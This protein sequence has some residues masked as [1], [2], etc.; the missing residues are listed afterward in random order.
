M[1]TYM[2]VYVLWFILA[3][4][5]WL[6]VV[7]YPTILENYLFQEANS[8]YPPGIKFKAFLMVTRKGGGL[9]SQQTAK[10]SPFAKDDIKIVGPT[11]A[12]TVP[13]VLWCQSSWTVRMHT[14][15]AQSFLP[16]PGQ[17]SFMARVL[18][19]IFFW[20]VH[21]KVLI[22]RIIP[23]I[24]KVWVV[25]WWLHMYGRR[26]SNILAFLYEKIWNHIVNGLIPT[27]VLT[28]IIPLKRVS[29]LTTSQILSQVASI[30]KTWGTWKICREI[31]IVS[32]LFP[33]LP[34]V[35][36][37]LP[38]A[39]WPAGVR[40]PRME[41]VGVDRWAGAK[42]TKAVPATTA[43]AAA[44]LDIWGAIFLGRLLKAAAGLAAGFFFNAKMAA[45]SWEASWFFDQE[46]KRI[47]Q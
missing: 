20:F 27:P 44:V 21:Q 37:M 46:Q 11:V 30:N 15:S 16:Q 34:T 39:W 10:W 6:R 38:F 28:Y 26:K 33:N 5:L 23:N 29:I 24:L 13:F 41:L 43:A 4:L 45:R 25:R 1:C 47:K 40:E 36:S 17:F 3:W 31:P 18:K 14:D 32:H 35:V 42:D 7:Q 19:L 9:S 2:A 12:D 22:K 8:L